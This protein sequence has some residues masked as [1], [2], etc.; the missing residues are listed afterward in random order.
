MATNLQIG[1]AVTLFVVGLVSFLAGLSI[2]LAREYQET[3]RSLSTQSTKIGGRAITD[4]GVAP[5]IDSASR[6]IEAV[7]Q[8]VRTAVGVGAFLCL[9][10]VAVAVIAFWMI[11]V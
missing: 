5:I 2:I 1:M 10:G 6:L 7:S 11:S 3:L 4:E 8:L 9:L